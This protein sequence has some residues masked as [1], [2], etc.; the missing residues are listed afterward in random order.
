MNERA[1]FTA[2]DVDEIVRS[3]K[4]LANDSW[5]SVE[6]ELQDNAEFLLITVEL[7]ARPLERNAPQ[8]MRV[9]QLLNERMPAKA[10]GD[11]SWMVV[12]VH[13]GEVVDSV[14]TGAI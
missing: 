9:F 14:M 5:S 4:A 7:S 1:T 8:R 12:F 3:L 13:D 2:A 11:Y 6:W 10:G